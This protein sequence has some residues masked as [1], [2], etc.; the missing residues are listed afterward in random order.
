MEKKLMARVNGKEIFE[1]DVDRFIEL[2]G[3]RAVAFKSE[4][5]KKQL[6]EEL[7]K[8]ELIFQDSLNRKFDE[9]SDFVKEMDEIRRS[10]LA[11]YYLNDLFG[12]IKISD[13]EI[14]TYYDE[15]KNLFKS[16]YAFRA[17]HILVES[18]EKALELKKK[19][20]NGVLFEDL[21]K[22]YSMCP[23]K[24]VGGDL[25]DFS[26]G[27]M[28]LEFENA[29][30]DANV[31]EITAPVKTQFGYHLIKLESKTEPKEL[32]LDEV[33]DEINQTLVKEKEK[34]V[35]V[36]RLDELMNNTDIERTY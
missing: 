16:K 14:K 34:I 17:K 3:N 22:E 19:C 32:S 18:E 28:V 27:Q 35:Y 6:C 10:I 24:E 5:G 7:I 15:N 1:S 20:E 23:S 26:Q 11:K 9:N 30:I 13:E 4:E 8:Q 2:M 25:G 12:S 31:N 21:A 36:K 29:C 33:K